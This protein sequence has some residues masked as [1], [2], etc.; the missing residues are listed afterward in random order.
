MLEIAL[1][2]SFVVLCAF[3]LQR[4]V[5]RMQTPSC[6]GCRATTLRDRDCPAEVLPL[7]CGENTLT[8]RVFAVCDTC[9]LILV[10]GLYVP[11]PKEVVDA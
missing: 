5:R 9:G 6:P 3:A 2:L 7:W 10:T 8:K 11:P 1:C 4:V